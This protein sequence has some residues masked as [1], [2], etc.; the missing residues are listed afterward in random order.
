MGP[1]GGGRATWHFTDI[2]RG[3]GALSAVLM[4]FY[5]LGFP[6]WLWRSAPVEQYSIWAVPPP[7]NPLQSRFS[8]V[9]NSLSAEF[10]CIPFPPHV[11]VIGA[12]GVDQGLTGAEVLK[13]MKSFCRSLKPYTLRVLDVS[14]GQ[15]YFQCVY[16]RI[17]QTKEV[18]MVNWR[19]RHLFHISNDRAGFINSSA[20]EHYMPHLSLIYGDLNETDKDL[21]KNMVKTQHSDILQDTEFLVS[22]LALYRTDPDDLE[23]KSWE[24]IGTF[25]LEGGT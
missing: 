13:K 16:L 17:A 14:S 10:S 15:K 3:L 24:L 22:S 9:I 12:F 4:F 7:E 2:L 1:P 8:T 21:A 5:V 18:L 25:P 20:A 6:G 19:A 11:T 23:M